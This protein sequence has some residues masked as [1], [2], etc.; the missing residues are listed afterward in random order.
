MAMIATKPVYLTQ[1]LRYGDSR[2]GTE[3]LNLSLNDEERNY[4]I[5]RQQHSTEIKEDFELL[6]VKGKDLSC[7]AVIR[8][9]PPSVKPYTILWA[10]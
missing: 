6:A 9:M 7:L 2:T 10:Y 3:S 1:H 5:C 4:Y 8:L